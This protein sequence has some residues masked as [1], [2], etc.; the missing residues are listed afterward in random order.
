M[1]RKAIFAGSFDPLTKGHLWI[2]E[3]A[4]RLFDEVVVATGINADKRAMFTLGEREEMLIEATKDLQNVWVTSLESEYI[5]RYAN[6]IGAQFLIRGI[7]NGTD[8]EHE[9]AM[10][11]VNGDIEPAVLEVFLMP[12]RELAELSSSTVKALIGPRGWERVI[13]KFVP[14]GVLRRLM[15]KRCSL[16]ANLI[17]AGARGD[18]QD[19]WDAVLLP[20]FSP[21]RRYHNWEHFAQVM[22]EFERIKHLLKDPLAVQFALALHDSVYNSHQKDAENVA[23][24]AAL[25]SKLA[26]KLGMS[27]AFAQRVSAL[28][29][30]TAYKEVPTDHD[31]KFLCDI[32]LSIL[33]A[34]EKDFDAYELAIQQEY[35][36]V[37]R[38]VFRPR[39][40]AIIFGLLLRHDSTLDSPLEKYLS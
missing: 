2:I 23:Q 4:S 9:K 5:V 12:P 31:A 10:R 28:I 17:E 15:Q 33:G 7:R 14:E 26:L 38:S 6:S 34:P 21:E 8:L 29:S 3:Q 40:R 13:A 36:W 32:D 39:R 11:A 1:T 22:A 16:W 37:E 30:Y 18:E 24:S 25:A 27:E 20:Y 35:A 19:F